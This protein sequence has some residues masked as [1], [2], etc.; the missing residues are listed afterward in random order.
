[1]TR[2]IPVLLAG[3]EGK[4]LRPL[5]SQ[6]RPKQFLK[7]L[8]NGQDSLFQA[9]LRRAMK[10]AAPDHIITVAS[11]RYKE[12][13]AQQMQAVDPALRQHVL[14]EPVGRN[15]AAAIALAAIHAANHFEDPLL[16][17]IPSDHQI[18]NDQSLVQAV[19][20]ARS[21]AFQGRIVVFGIEPT[22]A[23][24]NY[25]YILGGEKLSA[26]SRLH[27][28]RMFV[29]KPV[30]APLHWIASQPN[31][32]WNSG[33][34]LISAQTLFNEMK[35]RSRETLEQA[36]RAY[37]QGGQTET[38]Y[39]VSPYPYHEIQPRAID[40]MVMETSRKLAVLPVNIGWSDVGSWHA[41]WELSQAGGAGHSP[42]DKFLT[43]LARAS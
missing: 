35:K 1:M 34:F 6:A 5:S 37:R 27:Q 32:Y 9:S 30:G 13:V 19:I 22:R 26:H 31:C 11:G 2:I 12:L 7:L 36:S 33:M 14:L 20:H 38:G 17:I 40:T 10:V 15:T 24:S 43:T 39:A 21:A 18:G 42:L 3:G 29:E 28:V 41:L 4:R 25:G 16:W 8:P 23:D